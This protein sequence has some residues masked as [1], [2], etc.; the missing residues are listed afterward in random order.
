MLAKL[1]ATILRI[2]GWAE[3]NHLRASTQ[4]GF[5][6]DHR[7]AD[8]LFVLRTL[9][10][11]SIGGRQGKGKLY[12]CFVD[13]RKAFDTV[14]RDKLWQVLQRL[15]VGDR[16]L[17]CIQSMYAKDKA[18]LVY[19]DGLACTTVDPAPLASNRGAPYPDALWPV[20]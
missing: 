1:L 6:K 13:F 19:P 14:P 17:R 9:T 16:T 18:S 8:A 10:E 4:F 11:Q 20:H 2:S 3:V 7:T 5:R 12:T 15:G